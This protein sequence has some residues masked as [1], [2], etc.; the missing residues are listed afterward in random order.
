MAQSGPVQQE[1]GATVI[2][3]GAISGYCFDNYLQPFG[4]RL[5]GDEAGFGALASIRTWDKQLPHPGA[6]R[7]VHRSG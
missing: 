5:S 2:S 4:R 6:M 3:I 1:Y 7:N